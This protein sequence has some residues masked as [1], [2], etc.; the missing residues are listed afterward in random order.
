MNFLRDLRPLLNDE[1]NSPRGLGKAGKAY[2]LHR[3][4]AL[5]ERGLSVSIPDALK[6]I[7]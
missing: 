6:Y 2:A 1:K 4:P 3:L 5:K 7:S